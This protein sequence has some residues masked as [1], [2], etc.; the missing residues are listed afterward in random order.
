MPYSSVQISRAWVGLT[1]VIASAYTM[2]WRSALMLPGAQVVLVQQRAA[3]LTA[4]PRSATCAAAKM[5]W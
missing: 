2:P 3:R 4:S 1:V 5:P